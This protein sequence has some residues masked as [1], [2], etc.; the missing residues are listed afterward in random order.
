M[1]QHG[2]QGKCHRVGCE[3]LT[4]EE[5]CPADWKRLPR[6]CR[7]IIASEK[8]RAIRHGH[9]QLG[10][11][12]SQAIEWAVGFLYREDCLADLAQAKPFIL[13]ENMGLLGKLKAAFTGEGQL[14]DCRV[15][16]VPDAPYEPVIHN[17]VVYISS[18]ERLRQLL[19]D[20]AGGAQ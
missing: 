2:N 11:D 15:R 4:P 19:V 20:A 10:L 7:H 12:W 8:A 9:R 16:I 18:K 14:E 6:D 5:F 1:D 3:E 17:G 13:R